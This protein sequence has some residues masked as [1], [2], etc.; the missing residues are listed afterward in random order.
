VL[1]RT[2]PFDGDEVVAI[3]VNEPACA[4]FIASRMFSHFARPITADDPIAADLARDFAVHLDCGRLLRS[5]FMHP[6]FRTEATRA[7]LVK[8]PIEYVVGAARALQLP[9]DP[10]LLASLSG[11]GQVPFRPPNVGGWPQNGYWLSTAS[12]LARL[13]FAETATRLAKVAL[14]K[15]PAEAARLLSVDGWSPGT[16]AAL[17]K[18]DG[19]PEALAALALTAPEYVLA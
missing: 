1:G 9:I 15:T 10:R 16:A 8:M 5:I 13:Q 3:L 12:S 7:G 6:E 11:L 19:N 18:V 4:R 2:G 17:K 14:P